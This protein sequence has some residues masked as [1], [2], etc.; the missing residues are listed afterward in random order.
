MPPVPPA[1]FHLRPVATVADRALLPGDPGR[2]LAL[3]QVVLGDDRRMLNH[4]RGLW[5]Y[6]GT[7]SDGAPLTIQSTGM[8]GPSAAIVLEEL[9]GLGIRT[10]IRV[11]T[12]RA[13]ARDLRLGDLV[14][15][16]AVDAQDGTSA[17][18]GAAGRRDLGGPLALALADAAGRGGLIAAHD[19]L[20]APDP[21][22][23][24]R[25]W[26]AD[27]VLAAD[28]ETGAL[29]AVAARHGIAFGAVVAIA[30]D[31]EGARLDDEAQ[32]AAGEAAGRAAARA[33]GLA[34][35]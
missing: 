25:A 16:T 4:H 17:A 20:Y 1:P 24:T 2:A 32:A 19:V 34:C 21:V 10:A 9:A 28:L 33:L 23:Q 7:A 8:G 14:A 26:A 3:A 13:V 15:A 11:G 27:G 29:A 12:A 31:A 6:T 22:T 35:G 5:G 18:L 30:V